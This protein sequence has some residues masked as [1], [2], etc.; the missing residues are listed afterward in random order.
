MDLISLGIVI[1]SSLFGFLRGFVWEILKIVSILGSTLVSFWA[2]VSLFGRFNSLS[3][4]WMRYALGFGSGFGIFMIVG[5]AMLSLVSRVSSYVK[6]GHMRTVDKFA[7][8]IFGLLRGIMVILL[9]GFIVSQ[10]D[11]GMNDM[12]KDSYVMRILESNNSVITGLRNLLYFS[13]DRFSSFT[14][15]FQN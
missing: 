13:A 10:L 15:N 5:S 7:G 1:Y 12:L 14:E 2:G 11:L 6:K 9:L 4:I 3:K 8:F